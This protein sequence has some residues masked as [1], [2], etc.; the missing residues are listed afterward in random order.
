[1][2]A[3]TLRD[4]ASITSHLLGNRELLRR[5]HHAL[6]NRGYARLRPSPEERSPGSM[7]PIWQ[8]ELADLSG[9]VLQ[10]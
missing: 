10:E 5:H 8:P 1:M 3:G 7:L 6:W 2:I 4:R 9:P